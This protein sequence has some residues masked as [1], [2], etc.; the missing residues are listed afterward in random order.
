MTPYQQEWADARDSLAITLSYLNFPTDLA[1]VLAK[2]LGSPKAIRRM[3]SYLR[4]AKP[5]T[6]EMVIDEM[7]A[8]C[9]EIDAWR[10]KKE[11]ETA[12]ARYYQLRNE[13]FPEEE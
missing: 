7:L 3:D 9:E 13:V 8:I 10:K 6:L 11:S 1:D 2:N 12:N 4:Q 5:Q